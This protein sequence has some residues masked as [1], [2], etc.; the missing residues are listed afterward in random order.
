MILKLFTW[1]WLISVINFFFFYSALPPLTFLSF[2]CSDQGKGG[3]QGRERSAHSGALCDENG[4]GGTSAQGWHR[5]QCCHHQRAEIGGRRPHLSHRVGLPLP[6][7]TTTEV[8]V[9]FKFRIRFKSRQRN[10]GCARN[11]N[12]SCKIWSYRQTQ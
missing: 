7:K 4:D 8:R 12:S 2:P 11:L 6:A 10:T 5:L 3:R 9:W 1:S